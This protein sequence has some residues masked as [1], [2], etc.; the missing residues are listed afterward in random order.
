MVRAVAGYREEFYHS[1]EELKRATEVVTSC[2]QSILA[3]EKEKEYADLERD[4]AMADLNKANAILQERN[5]ALQVA[6]REY[7]ALK[8]K[9][10][11]K[12]AKALE[13]AV[14]EYKNN[15]KDTV[16]YLYLMRD[17]VDEYKMAIKK[18]DP[19]FD[20]DHYNNLIFGEPSTLAPK[21]HVGFEQLDLIGTP[22][23]TTEQKAAPPS[24]A[25]KRCQHRATTRGSSRPAHIPSSR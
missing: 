15:F 22:G 20:G 17:A 23:A 7:D 24:R 1:K 19:N 16:D 4:R 18:V 13:E 6:A 11:A 12:V 9:V 14:Q 3:L 10:A 2:R 8:A 21:D 25:L 5:R